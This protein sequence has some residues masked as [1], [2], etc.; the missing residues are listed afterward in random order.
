MTDQWYGIQTNKGWFVLETDHT[1]TQFRIRAARSSGGTV[2]IFNNHREPVRIEDVRRGNHMQ[3]YQIEDMAGV[4]SARDLIGKGRSLGEV[5][6][7]KPIR[8]K[9]YPERI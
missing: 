4:R 2:F 1:P 6:G 7:D 9:N 8:F 5:I 3:I